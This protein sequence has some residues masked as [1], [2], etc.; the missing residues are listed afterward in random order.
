MY[1]KFKFLVEV[2]GIA[3]QKCFSFNISTR[4]LYFYELVHTKY[5]VNTHIKVVINMQ[6]SLH[7]HMMSLLM[8][9]RH[10]ILKNKYY[11]YKVPTEFD[12]YP[13][14]ELLKKTNSAI[15]VEDCHHLYSVILELN[16]SF[17]TFSIWSQQQSSHCCPKEIWGLYLY[18]VEPCTLFFSMSIQGPK[19]HK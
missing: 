4:M 16:K 19:L 1:L 2:I 6:I 14:V 10:V 17:L 18:I 9:K 7:M 12:S 15:I 11:N 8:S 5:Y 13:Q 3:H